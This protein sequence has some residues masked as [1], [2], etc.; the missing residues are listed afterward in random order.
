[1]IPIVS[2][3]SIPYLGAFT[4]AEFLRDTNQTNVINVRASYYQEIDNIVNRL[5]EDL[6]IR[7][8]SILYQD[9][10]YGRAGFNGLKIALKKK[11]VPIASQ[12]VYLRNTTAVKTALLDITLGRPEAVLIVGSYLPAA[13]FI[14]LAESID[15]KPIFISISFVGTEALHKELKNSQ[16]TVIV[17]QVIPFPFDSTHPLSAR[18][19]KVIKKDFNFVSLEGYLVGRFAV[20]ALKQVGKNPTRKKLLQTIRQTKK[21]SIDG[22]DLEYSL[23]DNQGSDKVFLTSISN[24]KLSPISDLKSIFSISNHPSSRKNTVPATSSPL[25]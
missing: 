22:F 18:Y 5:F 4:G 16:S 10:S 11:N 3:A 8:I 9:D 20:E 6:K 14:K 15:F 25:N 13:E 2:E 1:M 21:F 17:T 23:Q 7:R 12:G 24:G 19:Q